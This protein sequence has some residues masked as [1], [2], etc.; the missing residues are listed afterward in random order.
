VKNG[1]FAKVLLT[2]DRLGKSQDDYRELIAELQK[3]IRPRDQFEQILLENLAFQFLRVA[4]VYEADAAVA[5]IL[6]RAV[7]E[8]LE[9]D[10]FEAR[11]GDPLREETFGAGKLPAA[12]LLMRYE[13]GIWR[14]IDR[15]MERLDRWRRAHY[16]CAGR[17]SGDPRWSSINNPA[18]I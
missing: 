10:G 16:D 13:A 8:K 7:R 18:E 1:I 12:D 9:S 2:A 5:P 3:S 4:R 15:I 17:Q 11:T 6:F 14:Q